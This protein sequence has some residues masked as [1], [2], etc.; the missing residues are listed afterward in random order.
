MQESYEG[1]R[2]EWAGAIRYSLL[3]EPKFVVHRE[4]P[5]LGAVKD[6][7]PVGGSYNGHE[8]YLWLLSDADRDLLLAETAT[9]DARD[10]ARRAA[11]EIAETDRLAALRA[12]VVPPEALA[13]FQRFQGDADAAWESGDHE[14]AAAL[15]R[16]YGDAIE[17]QGLAYAQIPGD[18]MELN[19]PGA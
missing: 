6:R 11:N 16:R 15:I 7:S 12:V 19:P 9:L 14:G 5:S 18:A 8:N 13:A 1:G 3:G 4:C 10:S 17:A 2:S